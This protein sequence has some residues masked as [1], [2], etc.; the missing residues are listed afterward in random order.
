M[1]IDQRFKK[2]VWIRSVLLLFY[3]KKVTTDNFLVTFKMLNSEIV[4]VLRPAAG[5][6]MATWSR[7]TWPSRISGK[8]EFLC[9]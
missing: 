3:N 7:S 6:V 1:Y 2:K 5:Q 4:V 9:L 8:E